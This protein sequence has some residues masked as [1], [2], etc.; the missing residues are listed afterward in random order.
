MDTVS[1]TDDVEEAP[2]PPQPSREHAF[3]SYDREHERQR[4]ILLRIGIAICFVGATLCVGGGVEFSL[5]ENERLHGWR[6][7]LCQIE[8]NHANASQQCVYFTVEHEQRHLC[9]VPSTIAREARF[10]EPPA[11]QS[12]QTPVDEREIER[13]RAVGARSVECLVPVANPVVAAQCVA[14]TT[15]TSYGAVVWRSYVERLVY[16]NDSPVDGSDALTNVTSMRRGTALAFI[17]AGLALFGVGLVSTFFTQ[18]LSFMR[19]LSRRAPRL[20]EAYRERHARRH[21]LH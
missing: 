19:Y 18:W 2:P 9:A 10:H 5:A 16:L 4:R 12:Q 6:L 1:L 11:C 20:T 14:S 7:S 8:K 21:H 13:W 3:H 15:S 17:V